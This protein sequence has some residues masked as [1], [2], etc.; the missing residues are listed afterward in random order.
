MH[1]SFTIRRA[2]R[3]AALPLALCCLAVMLHSNSFSQEIIGTDAVYDCYTGGPLDSV[4]HLQLPPKE[5]WRKVATPLFIV[6]QGPPY[7]MVHDLV[8]APGQNQV[9]TGKFDYGAVFHKDLEYERVHVYIY[10][11]GMSAW[12]KAGVFTTDWDGKIYAAIPQKGP[13]EYMIKMV[14]AGDLSIA[15]GFM[16][17][18]E[19]GRKTVVFDLDGTL[20]LND[21]EAVKDYIGIGDASSFAYAAKMVSLYKLR[22]YQIIYLSARPY[23]LVR[24]TRGW[25][26]KKGYPDTILHAT[27]NNNDS[28]DT[29]KAEQYKTEYL[30]NLKNS[31]HVDLVAAYGNTSGD[32]GAYQSAGI[33]NSGI[34]IIGDQ[35]G[36]EGTTP[37][38]D[39]YYAHYNWLTSILEC[40]Y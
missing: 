7:H 36:S 9:I 22:G 2:W 26:N 35:A 10:G 5:K 21:F 18:L 27:L 37:V 28:F 39:N 25:F 17:V 1:Y 23:W 24:E 32:I 8:V 15:Y 6:T 12:Q 31:V 29:A 30:L 3:M 38:Y 40:G 14:V 20:T 16:T 4:P 13:G 34:Y 11:T 19:P 33:P